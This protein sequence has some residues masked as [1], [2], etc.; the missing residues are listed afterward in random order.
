MTTSRRPCSATIFAIAA[1]TDAC[2]P[3]SELER[4]QID[5]VVAGEFFDIGDDGRVAAFRLAHRRT[6][7]VAGLRERIGGQ[8][9]E[10]ARSAGDDNDLFHDT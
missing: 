8:A 1:S 2:E 7:D 4:A 5:L 6:D 3:T 9:A 10:A